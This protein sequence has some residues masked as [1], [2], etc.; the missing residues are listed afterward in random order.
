MNGRHV[1]TEEETDALRR[2][3][4]P[5]GKTQEELAAQMGVTKN[6]LGKQLSRMGLQRN[7]RQPAWSD[8]ENRTLLELIERK[9]V[10]QV[11][12]TMRRTKAAVIGQLKKLRVSRR[13]RNGWY[14][15]RETAEIL[16]MEI[17]L[18]KKYMEEG[19]LRA[20]CHHGK[21][22]EPEGYQMWHIEEKDLRRFIRR[23][24]Q[25]LQGRNADMIQLVQILGGIEIPENLEQQG[26]REPARPAGIAIRN[27]SGDTAFGTQP[28]QG[29][30]ADRLVMLREKPG[31]AGI[32]LEAGSAT[33]DELEEMMMSR[34]GDRT[35]TKG[36]EGG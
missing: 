31:Q 14:T 27:T 26:R 1:W 3:Y 15:L 24:P 9:P 8:E 21:M 18:V 23:H 28:G 17:R 22:L 16:G 11:A 4:R 5:G 12:R 2:E 10:D 30:E 19:S 29:Q 7:R 35:A 33:A 25:D 36:T 32:W 13:N 20:T 34:S 6:Q